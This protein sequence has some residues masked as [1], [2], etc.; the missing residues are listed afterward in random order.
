M[1]IQLHDALTTAVERAVQ[2]GFYH[3]GNLLIPSSTIEI[4]ELFER[5]IKK[6]VVLDV[7][8]ELMTRVPIV[9]EE[10]IEFYHTYRNVLDTL[11]NEL[12]RVEKTTIDKV[13]AMF[14]SKERGIV[15]NILEILNS[16]GIIDIKSDGT[17]EVVFPTYISAIARI[18]LL[19]L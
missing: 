6:P 11:L 7:V 10:Y 1:K 8:E 5:D 12:M 16:R 19:R 4:G 17:I 3:R 2:E 18:L 13:L 14:E 15:M 9:R